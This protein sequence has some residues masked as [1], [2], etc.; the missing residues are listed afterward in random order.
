MEPLDLSTRPPRGPRERLAGLSFL[1]R[2]IDK[3]RATLPGGNPNGYRIAGMSKRLLDWMGVDEEAMR[4]AVAAAADDDDVV[5]W[6]R[7]HTDETQ[8]PAFSERME[9]RTLDDVRDIAYVHSLYPWLPDSE[10]RY[11]YDIL[12]EDDRRTYAAL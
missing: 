4:A 1:P 8:F 9:K 3:F 5:R 10:L 2:T 11:L 12:E 6:L 7:E